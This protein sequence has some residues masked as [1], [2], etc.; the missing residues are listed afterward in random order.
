M[1]I[2]EKLIR[3]AGEIVVLAFMLVIVST[4]AVSRYKVTLD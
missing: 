3:V 4:V 2:G 1:A